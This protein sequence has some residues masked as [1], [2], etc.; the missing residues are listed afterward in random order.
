VSLLFSFVIRN[1]GTLASHFF[2]FFFLQGVSPQPFSARREGGRRPLPP[3][4]HLS[5]RTSCTKRL[6][7]LFF[8]QYTPP[9]ITELCRIVATPPS[10]FF[11]LNFSKVVRNCRM[12]ERP[13]SIFRHKYSP[14]IFISSWAGR[15]QAGPYLFPPFTPLLFYPPSFTSFSESW[16]SDILYFTPPPFF[17]LFRP[18]FSVPLFWR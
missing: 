6:R 17:V 7:S 13:F 11:F 16:K 1:K 12:D 10:S 15:R 9:S 4:I 5:P 3:F 8:L 14:D 18:E 2:F